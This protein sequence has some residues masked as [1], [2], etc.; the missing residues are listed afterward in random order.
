VLLD[1]V[2][3]LA[4]STRVDD[5]LWSQLAA[6]YDEAQC[7]EAVMLVGFYRMLAGFVNTIGVEAEP[8]LPGWPV[9]GR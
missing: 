2:D 1:L 7:I 3:H 9:D 5:E 8:G 6:W 4:V